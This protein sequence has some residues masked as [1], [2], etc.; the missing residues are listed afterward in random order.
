MIRLMIVEDSATVRE[1]FVY[2]LASE[3]DIEIVGVAEDGQEAVAMAG[4]V[5]PDIILMDIN[6]PRLNGYEASRKIMQEHPVPILLM[7]ATWKIEEVEKIVES[8]Q[9]GVLGVYEKPYGPGHPRYKVLYA[10]IIA[11]IRLMSGVKVV[12]RWYHTVQHTPDDLKTTKERRRSFVLIGASTGGP[13]V[14]HTILKALPSDYPLP[15]LVAQHMSGEFIDSFV[16]WLDGE[17]ALNVKKA[18]EGEKIS[19]G[20]VYF[21]PAMQ[22]LTLGNNRIRLLRAGAGEFYVP[23]VSKLFASVYPLY[24][25]EAVAVLLSGMGNDGADEIA[26]LKKG[27][28]VT[29]AQDE[30]TSVVFGMA[31]EAIK[32]GGIEFVLPPNGIL[33]LL[34][35][36]QADQKEQ[37]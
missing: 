17:C 21:A 25:A 10:K 31:N 26:R 18:E 37:L 15:I 36:M 5:K 3:P 6:L 33:E 23:S 34:L 16:Q 35:S 7:T 28:A 1:M 11:D 4:R 13:P 30:A 20:H 24:A 29:I 8:M 22:H 19:A 14:L 32:M 12:R 2:A 27:G 9:I